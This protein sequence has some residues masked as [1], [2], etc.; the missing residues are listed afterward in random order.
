MK[1]SFDE[2]LRL[3]VEEII[4]HNPKKVILFG[5]RARGEE[6]P[7]SDIDIAVDMDIDFRQ[8]RKLKEKLEEVSGLYTVDLVFLNQTSPEFRQKILSEGKVL[9]EKG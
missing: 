4:K 1:K 3:I 2:Y 7:N 6:K 9:Y 5:S 8:Q